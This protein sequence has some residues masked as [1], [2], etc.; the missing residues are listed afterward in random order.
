MITINNKIAKITGS[1]LLS[2]LGVAGVKGQPLMNGQVTI[3]NLSVSRSDDKLFISMDIDVSALEVKSNREVIFTPALASDDHTLSL[4]AVMIAGRNRYYHHLRNNKLRPATTELYRRS[5]V[6]V[7]EYR[8]V[9]PYEKWMNTA[10]LVTLNEICGC[11]DETLAGE[12]EPLLALQLE[13]KVFV[14]DFVYIRPKAEPKI[15]VL[16]GSAFIDF[17]VNRTEIHENYRRNPVELQKILNTIDAVRNDADTRIIALSIKGYASPESPYSN[18]ERLAKGRTQTLKEYVQRQYNFPESIISTDYEPEDWA[19]L[20]RAVE[21]SDLQ[22][23]DAIL[24]LIRSNMEPDAKEWKIKKTYPA[25]YS[26]LLKN[27]YPGL[28][29]SDYAVKYEVRA[30]TDVAEIKRLLKMQP[31]KLSLNEMYLAAQEMA[32]G[33]EEYNETFEIAVR[34]F[35]NDEIANLNAANTAMH[36]RNLKNAERYLTK[37]GDTPEA[38]YARGIHAA[39]SEDYTTAQRLFTE[40]KRKGLVKAEDM[41]KQIEELKK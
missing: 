37:A 31:Q 13:P 29:H 17:P 30:Y 25:D 33:S 18:N 5:D 23:R 6:S 28:R 7:V 36:L 1:V 10:R 19:G 3:Q 24:A 16:E 39:L 8:T 9:V 27:I 12:N 11:S 2:L 32:P 14:P 22:N 41:L 40:A 35:P 38:I 21:N 20:E 34:M 4:P 26:W 15:N